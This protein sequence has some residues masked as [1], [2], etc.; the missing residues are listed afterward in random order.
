MTK[1]AAKTRKPA[2]MP[3]YRLDILWC[4]SE[5]DRLTSVL[6]TQQEGTDEYAETRQELDELT[7]SLKS[8]EDAEAGR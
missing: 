1:K 3:D 8:F 6:A 4:R 7:A 5:R 2:K